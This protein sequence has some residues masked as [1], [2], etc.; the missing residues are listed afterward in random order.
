MYTPGPLLLS[1]KETA[2]L[3]DV[4]A[5]LLAACKAFLARYDNA[6]VNAE[7]LFSDVAGQARAAIAL[8]EPS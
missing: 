2:H 1:A 8:A 5:A 4:N 6:L 3:Q 7:L